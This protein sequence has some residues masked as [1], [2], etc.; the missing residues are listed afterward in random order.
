MVGRR[1]LSPPS[2]CSGHAGTRDLI[3]GCGGVGRGTRPACP[4]DGGVSAASGRRALPP[5]HLHLPSSPLHLSY[6]NKSQ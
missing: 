1:T 5:L 4:S 3:S 2:G 6:E